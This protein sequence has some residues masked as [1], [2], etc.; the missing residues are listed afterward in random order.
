MLEQTGFVEIECR[1]TAGDRSVVRAR[2]P[3]RA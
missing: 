1:P 2:R 3:R